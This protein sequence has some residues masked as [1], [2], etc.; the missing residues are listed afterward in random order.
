[1]LA[2]GSIPMSWTFLK[3]D[4]NDYPFGDDEMKTIDNMRV[5][6]QRPKFTSHF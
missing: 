3:A 6:T 2:N 4:S 1:M 5:E